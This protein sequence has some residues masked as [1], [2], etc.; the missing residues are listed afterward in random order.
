MNKIHII[1]SREFKSR[2]KNRSFIIMSILGPLLIAGI[3]IIPLWLEKIEKTQVKHVVVV[4]ETYILGQTVKNFENYTFTIVPDVSV[5]DLRK[6]FA[7]SG[8]DAVLFIPKNIYSSN[9]VILY[10][11]VWVDNALKAYVGY[12]LRRDLEY[13]ALM[14]EN[15]KI[16]TIKRVSTPVFVGVQKWTK[17]GTYIDEEV[18]LT[19]KSTIAIT[20]ALII[21]IFIFMYGVLVL[22]GVIEEKSSRVV[23][24]IVSS[25]RPIQFMAGKVLGIGTIGL[26]QFLVWIILTFSIVFSAQQILFPETYNPTPLP[27]LASSLQTTHNGA[28]QLT[29]QSNNIEYA[30]NLF[31]SLNGVNWP[32]MLLAFIFFFIFG[33]LL[34]ASIFAGIGA[35]LDQDSDTQ[36]FIIPIT[37]PLILTL[38]LLNGIIANPNGSIAIWLSYIPFTS[39]IAMMARIPFGVPYWQ[40]TISACILIISC[41]VSIWFASKMY[42]SGLLMYGKKVTFFSIFKLI[43]QKK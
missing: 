13:M 37:L 5:E 28:E 26:V 27:E 42:K 1:F 8:Y 4:D 36:Q 41:I 18:S 17:D 23:E 38:L 3:L 7:N 21:Y 31:Q 10:S 20:A 19:K 30:V 29:S 11:N 35:V 6:D 39:P 15:V 16:E 22:R 43:R 12:A 14:K 24:V 25:V 9:Q 32:V 33:Y 40:V 2:I 34:Y